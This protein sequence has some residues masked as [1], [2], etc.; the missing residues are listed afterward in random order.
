VDA[1]RARRAKIVFIMVSV[2]RLQNVLCTVLKATRREK[3]REASTNV[4]TYVVY[5]GSYF[6][7]LRD[8][9]VQEGNLVNDIVKS[10]LCPP[11]V[12]FVPFQD[13]I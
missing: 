9:R 2:F 4:L 3:A 6:N 7:I 12:A 8:L 11:H 5:R 10:V 1:K 13:G